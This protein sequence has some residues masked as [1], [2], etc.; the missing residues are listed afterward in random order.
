MTDRLYDIFIAG[1][2]V[3]GCGIARDAAGRGYSVFLAEMNDL[4]SGTS[5]WSTKLIHGGLR[6]LEHYEFRLVRE[7]LKERETLWDAAPHII[8]P[9]R[10][11]LP[12]H[13]GL[14]PAWMLRLGLFLYDNIGGRRKLPASRMVDL[15]SGPAG[16]PLKPGFKKGFEYSDCRMDDA[17]LVVLNARSAA[18]HGAVIRTR[19]EVTHAEREGAG[20]RIT[21]RGGVTGAAQTIRARA[22]VN[23]GGPW[24]DMVV[25]RTGETR[26]ARNVR[27]VKGSHIVVKR[28]YDHDL[29]YIFQ[30]ADGR[31]IFAIPYED[32]FTMIG[33][34]DE[35]F[36]GDPAAA[37]CSAEETDYLLRAAGEYFAA[38]LRAEDV[39]WT[40]AGVRPLFDEGGGEAARKATR[41]Y[42][43]HGEGGGET[44]FALHIFGGKLTTYRRL[45]EA[46]VAKLEDA[47]GRKGAPWTAGAALPG[48]RFAAGGF[49]D[50]AQSFAAAHP[51][52]D[53]AAAR[54][55]TRLYG[56]E[57]GSVIDGARALA[58]LG[59]HFGGGLYESEVR[60]LMKNEWARTAEDVLWRRTKLGLKLSAD[61]A[62]QL[63]NYMAQA[64]NASAAG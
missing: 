21:L 1:G 18:E 39:V 26:N 16:A 35:D 38:P 14:R 48:G 31:I 49:E 34:T 51:Y 13:A 25:N 52:L 43:L 47:L 23:A 58:D 60:W 30:T 61:G 44:G 53:T 57:A 3:N 27:L 28:L 32:D 46:A 64:Q 17:R 45:A 59:R 8:W 2:G 10:F 11:V 19:T 40:F 4:A 5:S 56:T 62:A 7:S 55:L 37:V 24:V 50:L 54:R 9:A 36:E 29:C 33:T 6:Y 12:H 41:D 42:K 15:A 20:W 63:H 22:F